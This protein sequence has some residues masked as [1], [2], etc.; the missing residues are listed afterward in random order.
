MGREGGNECARGGG[1][2]KSRGMD[3]GDV[4]KE[5]GRTGKGESKVVR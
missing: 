3:I 1:G 2:E 4:P 5:R